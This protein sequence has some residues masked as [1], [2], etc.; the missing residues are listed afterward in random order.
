MAL[1]KE[2]IRRH[3]SESG[4]HVQRVSAGEEPD[5]P[6]FMYTIGNHQHG[7]PELLIIGPTASQFIDLLNYLGEI[8]RKL[9][10][11]FGHEELVDLG[12]KFPV[13]IV[14]AGAEGRN[15]YAIQVGVFYGTEDF[16]IRQVLLCD[17]LGRWPDNPDCEEP[18]RNQPILGPRRQ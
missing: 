2:I 17:Q 14:D 1:P 12:A 16:E 18:Y 4:Q 13:R 5:E 8:Q 3:I 7:L 15:D 9:G 10:R 6:A 11:A